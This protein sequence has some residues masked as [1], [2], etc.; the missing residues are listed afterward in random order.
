MTGQLGSKGQSQARGRP[1][2]SAS[3]PD[4]YS[5]VGSLAEATEER[6]LA[7]AL[8]MQVASVSPAASPYSHQ[9]WKICSGQRLLMVNMSDD[10]GRS[11]GEE[12]I[13]SVA[14]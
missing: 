14:I 12:G 2:V 6:E 1:W 13:F 4:P 10:G 9:W 7:K 11:K 3:L 8:C 5:P